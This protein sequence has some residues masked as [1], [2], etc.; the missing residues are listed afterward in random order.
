MLSIQNLKEIGVNTKEG[1]E[2]CLNNEQ[3]YLKM[4]KKTMEGDNVEKL[5]AAIE[6]NDLDKAFEIAHNLKG[7]TGNLSLAPLYQPLSEMTEHLRAREQMDYSSYIETI[8]ANKEKLA[9]LCRD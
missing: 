4:V 2:R 8:T 9:A 7:V 6:A 3:F 1:L 5:K